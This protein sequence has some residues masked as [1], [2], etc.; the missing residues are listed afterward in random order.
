[1]EFLFLISYLSLIPEIVLVV[2]ETEIIGASTIAVIGGG[3]KGHF[4]NDFCLRAMSEGHKVYILS[5]RDYENNSPYHLHAN[6]DTGEDIESQFNKLL[7]SENQLDLFLY[8]T[9]SG[10]G[11]WDATDFQSTSKFFKDEDWLYNLRVNVIIP[12]NLSILALKKMVKGSKLIYM[13]TG[14]SYNMEDDNPPFIPSYYGGKAFQ[15]HIMK[16]FSAYNDKGAIATSI[17]GH[18][19]YI[20]KEYYKKVFDR[21]Y[22]HIMNINE[23]HNGRIIAI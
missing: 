12:Y 17:T 7:E 10:R 18:F 14:R 5:H 1:M 23:S 16:A 4:G 2:V 21:A 3:K 8:N 11:P 20:D 22:D 19:N 9:V 15:N 6:F 13:T